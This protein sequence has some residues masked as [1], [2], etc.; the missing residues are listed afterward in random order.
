MSVQKL[1]TGATAVNAAG[2]AFIP[3]DLNPRQRQVQAILTGTGAIT[4]TVLVEVSLNGTNFA[5]FASLSLSGSA[6]DSK[7]SQVLAEDCWVRTTVSALTG[8]GATVS[9]LVN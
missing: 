2:A 5:Q 6:Y 1:L 9:T 3:K 7:L 4:A 8:T